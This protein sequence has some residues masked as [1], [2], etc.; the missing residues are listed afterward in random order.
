[1]NCELTKIHQTSSILEY[2]ARGMIY[3]LYK[4]GII[5]TAYK[6]CQQHMITYKE[7]V[8]VHAAKSSFNIFK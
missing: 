2:Y 7:T 5:T 3:G 4:K 6:I 1:M 8:V